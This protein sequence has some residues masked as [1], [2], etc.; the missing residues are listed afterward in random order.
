MKVFGLKGN[1]A[2]FEGEYGMRRCIIWG[3]GR[4]Y[5]EIFSSIHFEIAKGNMMLLA[6]VAKPEDTVG[7]IRDGYHIIN[8]G[9]LPDIEFDYLIVAS[10]L[11]YNEIRKEAIGEGV[12]P[13]KIL[14]G[15]IFKLPLFDFKRYTNLLENPIT[16]LSNDC[17]GGMLYHALYLPFSSPTIN[18]YVPRDS[19]CKMIS[20]LE[21]YLSEPLQLKREGNIRKNFCP[22][23]KIGD[24]EN[25]IILEFSH[26]V[27]F[28]AGW[29]LWERRKK[30]VNYNNIFVK[31]GFDYD[32]KSE[33]YLKVFDSIA[34]K[35]I[36]FYSAE[37]NIDN[38]VY[39][40]SFENYVKNGGSWT[41][42]VGY[43]SFCRQMDPL[44]K[45]IDI[46]K[47]LNG[48]KNYIREI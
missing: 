5:E 33:E 22:I 14:N 23:G 9:E 17:W 2:K 10:T 1:S 34:Y 11:W 16:I 30:R 24:G 46:L 42:A 12:P 29:S 20:N 43:N 19:Y 45:A 8:K 40:K 26:N 32:E 21:Y 44:F 41:R 37:T 7:T 28:E 35:K 3:L 36:C 48:E 38:V 31:M 15:N 6:L 4:E 18:M 47:M 25:E 13:L 39:L 27:T